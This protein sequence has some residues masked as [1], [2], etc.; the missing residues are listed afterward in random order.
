MP[1]GISSLEEE[2]DHLAL[3]VGL[4][5]LARDDDQVAVA[6]ELDRLERAAE[7]VV[8]GDRDRAEPVRLGVV[9]QVARP[10]PRS[11][12]TSEVCRWRS[13]R[14]H[15]RSASGSSGCDA[16]R[17]LRRLP[18]GPRRARRARRATSA[19]VLPSTLRSRLL[20]RAAR[21]ARSF[22]ASRASAAAASSG[23]SCDARRRRRSRRRRRRASSETRARPSSAGHEDRGLVQDRGAARARRGPCAR[24]RGRAARA[25]SSAGPASGFVRRKTSSQS[26]SS[27]SART[28]ARDER[29]LAGPPLERRRAFASCAG[30]EELGVDALGDDRGTRPGSARAAACGRLRRRATARRCAPSEPLALRRAR[31]VAEPLGRE[32]ARDGRARARL[33]QREVREARQPRLEAVD[34]VEVARGRARARGSPARRPA[35]RSGCGARSGTAGPTAISR[36]VGAVAQRAPA[37]GEVGRAVRRREHRHRVPALAQRRGDA[38]DVLVDVVRLRPRERRHE[39]DAESHGRPSLAPR[40]TAAP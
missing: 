11:R 40:P 25:G 39:A 2:A 15:S 34:D 10:R 38:G 28:T 36:R 24:A 26:G 3:A 5:L 32:E 12:A 20:A 4:H 13:A 22:S 18:R 21:G 9:E 8:V 7:D 35:R 29:A 19:K 37:G 17:V 1:R 30:L 6:R 27:R 31:R 23:C 16:V 33:A 14:I